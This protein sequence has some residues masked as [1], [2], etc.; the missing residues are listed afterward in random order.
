MS[1]LSNYG[2]SINSSPFDAIRKINDNGIEHWEARELMLVL[3]YVRW[4]NFEELIKKAKI[5]CQN[6]GAK[7]K[8]HFTDASKMVEIGSG[9]SRDSKD[10][11]LSRY[12]CY[13]TAMNGDPRKPEIAAAQSYFA[14][15]T[16][17]R[18]SQQDSLSASVLDIQLIGDALTVAFE[19]TGLNPMLVAGVKLNA[20][21]AQ[22]P[23]LKPSLEEG[24]KFLAASNSI[25]DT[26][27]TPTALGEK[28]GVSARKVNQM[29]LEHG[30]QIKNPKHGM[31]GHK[32]EPAYLPTDRG[33]EFC[34]FT[35]ATGRDKDNTTYQHLKWYPS[36]LNAI[37]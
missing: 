32:T 34:D 16:F 22:Y 31:R 23:Q 26:L 1:N 9:A 15:K 37:S 36:V 14:V 35:A 18:E 30:L 19:G 25:E 12:A 5:A 4:Q 24:R 28:L 10:Y 3:G 33:S 29:L 13:L 2:N 27:L 6:T 20:I 11:K 21:Q 7:I 17:E 8:D